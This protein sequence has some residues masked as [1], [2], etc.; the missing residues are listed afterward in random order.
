VVE[1]AILG[2]LEARSGAE[3]VALGGST[4]RALL[5]MRLLEAGRVTGR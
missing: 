2:P 3:P 5:A 1:F 4:Q